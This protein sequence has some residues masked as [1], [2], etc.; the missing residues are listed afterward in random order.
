MKV[1]VTGGAGYVGSVTVDHLIRNGHSVTVFDN[2]ERGHAAAVHPSAQLR[3]GDLRD[4]EEVVRAV[5]EC[6]PD[7]IIHFASYAYVGE[8][9]A[10]PLEYFE[11]NVSGSL[12][13]MAAAKSAG[14]GKFIFSSSCATYG[15]PQALPITEETPQVPINPYGES[16]LIV[17]RMLEWMQ[18]IHGIDIVILR[19]FNACGA[20][21]TLG[22]DHSPETH[23]IPLAL[24]SAADATRLFRIFGAQYDT[25]DRTC[26]RDYVHVK[27][28]AQA[29][30]L[31]LKP[32]LNLAVNLGA[33]QGASVREVLD[34]V[35]TVTGRKANAVED[36][37]R[38]GDPPILIA[39]NQ[40]AQ[41]ELGW[42]PEHSTLH[43]IVSDAWKWMCRNPHGYANRHQNAC[44]QTDA[45]QM[46]DDA[47]IQSPLKGSA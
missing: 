1:F 10:K 26:I 32:G 6:M 18:K 47:S 43:E 2:L 4:K 9:M 24:Q 17:E 36:E 29:H 39:D 31:A 14:V 21:E 3:V 41:Q 44:A 28:L 16:K 11:N 34:I 46:K 8:S 12:N 20:T 35:Q 45:T 30:L 23:A 7:A 13:L 37:A 25:P 40:R 33:G 19:Y 5:A 15:V 42:I 38:V 22:E 27:D